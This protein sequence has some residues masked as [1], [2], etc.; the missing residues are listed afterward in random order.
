MSRPLNQTPRPQ[1]AE[2]HTH[3]DGLR[4]CGM[5]EERLDAWSVVEGLL[6]RTEWTSQQAANH[7]Q[8]TIKTSQHDLDT[9]G[10]F[11]TLY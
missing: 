9:C 8:Q 2:E 5:C 3:Q 10:L 6:S 7:K 1:S 11:L 4:V